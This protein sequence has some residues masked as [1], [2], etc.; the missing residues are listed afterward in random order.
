MAALPAATSGTSTVTGADGDADDPALRDVVAPLVGTFY[1]AAEPGG[2]PFV[3]PHERVEKGQTVGIVEAMKL[4][5]PVV[6]EWA[7]E[8]VEVAVSDGESVEFG[9]ILVRLRVDTA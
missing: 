3:S 9:E 4:M 1:V 6:A 5:T 2:R 7:G 8:V